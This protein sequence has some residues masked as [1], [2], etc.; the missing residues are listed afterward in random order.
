MLKGCDYMN[1]ALKRTL[2]YIAVLASAF[3][4]I[5]LVITAVLQGVPAGTPAVLTETQSK[6]SYWL[7]SF[8][9]HIAVYS[10]KEAS[11]PMIETTIDIE[12]LRAVDRTLLDTGIGT[13]T[14]EDVLKLLEDFGS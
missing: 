11:F 8:N 2:L 4:I 1:I 9:G 7:R 13:A 6:D 10:S 3:M 12:G 14:Y 5:A